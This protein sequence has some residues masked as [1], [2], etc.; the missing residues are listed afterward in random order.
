MLVNEV[1]MAEHTLSW[2]AGDTKLGRMVERADGCA[3]N[4]RD[5]NRLGEGASKSHVKFNKLGKNWHINKST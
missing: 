3:A 1:V 5:L 2:F 4:Q